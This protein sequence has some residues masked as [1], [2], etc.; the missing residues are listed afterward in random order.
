LFSHVSYQKWRQQPVYLVRAI[1][2][3]YPDY[4]HLYAARILIRALSGI[5]SPQRERAL[6]YKEP[7]AIKSPQRD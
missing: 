3:I 2:L 7:S 5:K 6:S 1:N 4:H